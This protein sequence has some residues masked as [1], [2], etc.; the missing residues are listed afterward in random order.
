MFVLPY[1]M[2]HIIWCRMATCSAPTKALGEIVGC[3][4]TIPTLVPVS[5][6]QSE[7]PHGPRGQVVRPSGT[8]LDGELTVAL[9][10]INAQLTRFVGVDATETSPLWA[11]EMNIISTSPRGRP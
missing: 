5:I 9:A 4:S 8:V 11:N 6:A 3:Y 2:W 1:S 10:D 7:I